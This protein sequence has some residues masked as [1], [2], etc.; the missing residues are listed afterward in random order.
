MEL[1]LF[2]TKPLNQ[3]AGVIYNEYPFTEKEKNTQN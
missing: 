2:C 3:E 1:R